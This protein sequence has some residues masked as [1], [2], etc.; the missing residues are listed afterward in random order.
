MNLRTLVITL[1]IVPAIAHAQSDTLSL[2]ALH[3]AAEQQDPRARELALLSAQSRLRRLNLDT[4]HRPSF[5]IESQAQYQS[6]VA[7]VPV[8]LPG[9]ATIPSPAH[10]TYDAHLNVQQ[11]LFD[12][13]RAPRRALEDAQLGE[14][15]SRLRTALYNSRQTVNDLYFSA[16][17]SQ[18]QAEEIE[19]TITDLDAQVRSA[20]TRAREG[21][22]L[23]SEERIFQAE[24]LKR[25]QLLAELRTSRRAA[26]SVLADLTN[27][28]IDSAAILSAPDVGDAITATRARLADLKKRPEFEQF[29]A[30]R[31]TLEKQEAART[32]QD[33][34]RISAFGRAGYGRPGLNPL[35]DKFDDY[36]LVGVQLQWSPFTWGNTDRDRESLAIQR[37]I[38][39]AEEQAFADNLRRGVIQDLASIDR[40]GETLAMDDEIIG[41]RERIAAET[42]I[43]YAEGVVLAPEYVDRETDVLSARIARAGHRA[44]LA[45]SRARVLTT[46]GIEVR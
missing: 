17:R 19:T 1:A 26:L 34:P 36:W 43:R 7:R 13:T 40:L 11:R 3:R 31:N 8:T 29:A 18:T 42:R 37:Q 33:K 4:E 14:S 23:P 24:L 30:T 27:S 44:E 9:G 45:Q 38:V 2:S 12:A 15:R 21:T 16:L 6:D 20:A 39:N 41:L 35:S 25:R 22:A 5:A 46:L 32:A 10:D 28:R